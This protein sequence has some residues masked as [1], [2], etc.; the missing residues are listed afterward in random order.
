MI[1]ADLIY[2]FKTRRVWWFTASSRTKARFARTSLGSFWLGLSNLLS[3]LAL[4]SV[5]GTVFNVENF[6]VYFIYLGI[7]LVIWNTLCASIISAPD[8]F[9]HNASNIK[10][11]NI[12]PLFYTL[13]EWAFQVQTFVQSFGLVFVVLSIFNPSII[14]NLLIYS[15]FPLLNLI[16]FIYWFPLVICILGSRFSDLCQLVPI[17]MQIIFLIS[18]ILY[19]KDSLGSL[20]WISNYNFIYRVLEPLRTSVLEGYI[21]LEEAIFFLFFNIIGFILALKLLNNHR[22]KLPFLV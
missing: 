20:K 12:N 15:F 13:E 7:G 21:N 11:L 2:C 22:T 6:R 19:M 9:N 18:P 17:A 8:L 5:Y 14:L 4:G 1:I 3:I 16:L 10:N